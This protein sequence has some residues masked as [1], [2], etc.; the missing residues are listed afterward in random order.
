MELRSLRRTFEQIA[1][2]T[3]PCDAHRPAGGYAGCPACITP[4][5]ANRKGAQRAVQEALAQ[6]YQLTEADKETMRQEQLAT[7]DVLL[8]KMLSDALTS[9]E[10]I[11]RARAVTAAAR[12]MERQARLAGLDAPTR[13]SIDPELDDAVAAALAELSELPMPTADQ[14]T[15]RGDR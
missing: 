4:L 12:L 6:G 8:R 2:S 14:L 1:A 7:S 11:D 10:P 15:E 13:V 5:Y 3:L 9:T